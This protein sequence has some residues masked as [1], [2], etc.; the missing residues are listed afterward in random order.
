MMV[1]LNL[2]ARRMV[3][4]LELVRQHGWKGVVTLASYLARRAVGDLTGPGR[5]CPVCHWSGREFRP[6]LV[7]SPGYV[8]PR[9]MCPACGCLERHRSYA[10]WYRRFLQHEYAGRR[11]RVL[12]FAPE[13]G[14]GALFRE[15]AASYEQSVYEAPAP[16]HIQLD[17][18]DLRLP[19]SSYDIFLIN[20]VLR[21]VGDLPAAV[22]ETYRTLKPGGAV[23]A[24]ELVG[25]G[26]PTLDFERPD[27]H[28]SRRSFGER[29][30]AQR[31]APFDV[32]LVS[33]AELL[34]PAER[35]RYNAPVSD[36]RMIVL[37]KRAA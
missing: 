8:R 22:R 12:H 15:Y 37:R 17:L 24:G 14:I 33:P 9:A 7:L 25:M 18:C 34:T 19:D 11:P 2:A 29:D 1:S 21:D 3:P 31:F 6:V 26:R 23:L 28:R 5:E 13:P 36:W 4:P 10:P 20:A 35:V 16:G 30:L 27:A 32:E